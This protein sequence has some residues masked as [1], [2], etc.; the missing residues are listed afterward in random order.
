MGIFHISG[1]DYTN[2]APDGFLKRFEN[3]FQSFFAPVPLKL[4][5]RNPHL[6]LSF[7]RR[8]EAGNELHIC[9]VNTDQQ[10]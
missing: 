10:K 2:G 3:L 8:V 1:Q 4:Q 5:C 6:T 9:I 7:L